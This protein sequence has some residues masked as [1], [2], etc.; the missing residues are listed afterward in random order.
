VRSAD[1]RVRLAGVHTARDHVGGDFGEQTDVQCYVTRTSTGILCAPSRRGQTGT[2]IWTK[3]LHNIVMV[4]DNPADTTLLRQ[5]LNE[6][7][8][9]YT[10]Q[11]LCDGEAALNYVRHHCIQ[12]GAEPC[13]IIIDLHLPR[14]D[15]ATVL[16]AI[17]TEPVLKHIRVAV[18]TTMA[19]PAE[20]AEVLSLGVQLYRKKPMDWEGFV[21]LAGELIAL[22]KQNDMHVTAVQG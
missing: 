5:A 19:S 16:R 17:K 3:T 21:Q 6:Q 15:G 20:K 1:E 18:L 12:P 8:E 10:L 7:G 11:V 22:C 14:Y 9:P 2:Q 13:L 4:E